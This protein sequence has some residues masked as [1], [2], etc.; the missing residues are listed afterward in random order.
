MP[1]EPSRESART[2]SGP[3]GCR[4]CPVPP[5]I[6]RLVYL[7]FDWWPKCG[8]VLLICLVIGPSAK[9][10][11]CKGHRGKPGPVWHYTTISPADQQHAPT[12][13]NPT[14]IPRLGRH[15]PQ[16]GRETHLQAARGRPRTPARLQLG[17]PP[18]HSHAPPVRRASIHR[19]AL[20][21]PVRGPFRER[22]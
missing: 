17:A 6:K 15:P 5:H 9:H 12:F 11:Y 1:E 13:L 19:A 22:S 10:T 16:P 14:Q 4:S 20:S 8:Q 2:L 3:C 21:M 18:T 7:V